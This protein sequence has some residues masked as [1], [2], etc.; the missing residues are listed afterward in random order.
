M[1]TSRRSHLALLGAVPLGLKG[2]GAPWS[3]EWDR[4]L[5]HK[6]VESANRHFD[7]KELMIRRHVGS[8]Y[9]YHSSLR[10]IDGHPTRESL[11]Y[12]LLLLEEGSDANRERAAR[13]AERVIALQEVDSA[14]KWYGIWGYYLEE[15]AP[16]MTPA[17]WNWADFNGSVLLMIESRHGSRLPKELRKNIA[18]SIQHAA[19][20]VRRRNVSM[21]YTNIAIQGTFV[22]MAAAELLGDR[23]LREYAVDRWNR[24]A[25]TVDQT[26]SFAE[27]NSPTYARVSIENLTRIRMVV[28]DGRFLDLTDRIH[29]R[30]WTHLAVRWHSPTMQLA[31]PMS[32]CYSTDIG[33]PLWLQK[34]T[35]GALQF[36]TLDELRNGTL[37]D[38]DAAVYDFRCPQSLIGKFLETPKPAQHREVFLPAEAPITP[39]QG[40]T[41][42]E[43]AFTL[44]SI[45]RGDFWIQRRPLL[46]YWGGNS[47]PA[48][49]LQ[50]RFIKDNYDFSSA[51]I[52]TV[53]E[54][55][56]VAGVV[57]FR[58]PGG[59]KHISLDPVPA[60]G[61]SARRLRMR[62][63]LAGV[64]EK[65]RILEKTG[66]VAVDLGGAYLSLHWAG[67]A[68]QDQTIVLSTSRE[69]GM[70]V[71]SADFLKADAPRTIRWKDAAWGA[72]VLTIDGPAG[73][74][75]QFANRQKKPRLSIGAESVELV[76]DAMALKAG[77]L[78]RAIA[79]Q[80]RL[81]S[82]TVSGKPVELRRLSEE[83]LHSV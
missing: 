75:E 32:R 79:E 74:L 20:S 10:N 59:D 54:Q 55:N 71:I 33:S 15:P 43:P 5:I 53:Q 35:G 13:V 63:D 19:Y 57:T 4:I 1:Q 61:F 76:W 48:R 22:V 29:Q 9:N 41:W 42:R 36:A 49:Y 78:P 31:G 60:E 18:G 47:R 66:S 28:R 52:Y 64:P 7:E 17:D 51:L 70:L 80:D 37:A 46:A 62:L 16:K 2:A 69:E 12:A 83:R 67:G 65:A 44:G 56:R 21:S 58:S 38:S 6:A 45:N 68:F 23:E 24:F 40:T 11:A 72:F 34:G 26:G 50:M 39:I 8:A 3:P 27:Y 77:I 73:S 25:Q 30:A 82:A 81:Y 14:S